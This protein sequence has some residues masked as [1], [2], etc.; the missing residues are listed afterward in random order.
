MEKDEEEEE[1][2]NDFNASDDAAAVV[3]EVADAFDDQPPLDNIVDKVIVGVEDVRERNTGS[4][5]ES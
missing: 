3:E 4:C 1:D 5:S 2:V